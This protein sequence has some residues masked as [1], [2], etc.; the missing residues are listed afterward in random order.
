MTDYKN[1]KGF[2]EILS[3]W[4]SSNGNSTTPYWQTLS[5][6][7]GDSVE[8][9][10]SWFKRERN[11][12]GLNKSNGRTM[13]QS[14]VVGVFDVETLPLK[15]EGHLWAIHDQ[16]IPHTMIKDSWKMLGWA[17]KVLG[18]NKIYSDIMTPKEA[19]ERN[20]FNVVQSARAFM[21]KLD[22]VIWHN[23]NDFDAKIL[24]SELAYHKLDPLHYRS[25]DT[26]QLIRS[27]FKLPSYKLDYVNTYFGITRKIHNDG[28][29][30]WDKC[31]KG[32]KKSLKEMETYNQGDI[33]ANEDLFWTIQPYVK[34]LPNFSTYKTEV[35]KKECN[36]GGTFAIDKK[37]PY[38]YTN[39]AK[40]ERYV[41]GSCGSITRG[42]KTVLSKSSSTNLLTGY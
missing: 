23:G 14:P 15:I 21:D 37:H 13:Q 39:L 5:E 32:D 12:R 29:V 10:K 18:E 36:C 7:Y 3:M 2:Q 41:C 38:W 4:Q 25:I 27:T 33:V 42:R 40:Y 34:G 26:L 11:K 35:T 30:L 8:A 19:I 28:Q 9:I 31:L 6:K 20:S 22:I 1:E 24:N 16:Y 17:G